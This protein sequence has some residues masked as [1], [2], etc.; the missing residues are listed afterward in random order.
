MNRFWR[1]TRLEKHFP[2]DPLNTDPPA[3]PPAQP[4]EIVCAACGCKIARSG[5]ILSTGETYKKF[6]KHEQTIEGKDREISALNAE[7]TR[8]KE[9]VTAL[10][11]KLGAG[12]SSGHRPGNRIQ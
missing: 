7:L 5:E 9:E 4:R 8:V 1:N 11:A 6:L 10:N 3:T 2:D 12:S